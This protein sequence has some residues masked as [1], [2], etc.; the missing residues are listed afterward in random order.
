[1][2]S[3]FYRVREI[4]AL[5]GVSEARVYQMISERTIPAVR[6][7]G[8]IR[9]PKRAWESWLEATAATAIGRVRHD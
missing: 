6:V 8:A 4:A 5:L 7:S 3:E 9:I 1:M 2:P